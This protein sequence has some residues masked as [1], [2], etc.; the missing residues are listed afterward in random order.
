MS[1]KM[2]L[3]SAEMRNRSSVGKGEEE[4]AEECVEA[5]MPTVGPNPS[6]ST[7]MNLKPLQVCLSVFPEK[8]NGGGKIYTK[9]W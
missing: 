4:R 1:W 6:V 2:A 8:F 3:S 5:E 7:C 9:C